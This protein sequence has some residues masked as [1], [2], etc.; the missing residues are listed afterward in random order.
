[1]K[2]YKVK[3]KTPAKL[4][5]QEPEVDIK[6]EDFV[7]RRDLTFADHQNLGD[8]IRLHNRPDILPEGTPIHKIVSEGYI[9]FTNDASGQ[10]ETEKYFLAVPYR[11][12]AVL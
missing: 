12:V 1:M 5:T 9:V 7:V 11:D 6:I 10:T 3:R 4:I 8:P 2:M